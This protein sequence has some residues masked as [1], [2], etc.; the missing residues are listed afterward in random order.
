[1]SLDTYAGLKAA[2]AS[3]LNKTNLTASIPDFITLAEAVMSR[4]ISSIG[5]VDNYA[6]VEVGEEGWGLPFSADEVASV[7]YNG[8]PLTYLSPDRVGEVVNTNPG[9]YTIDGSTLKVAPAGTVT[10]RMTKSFCPLSSSVPYNWLLRSHPDAYLYGSLM[11]AAP[12]LRDDERIPVWGNFFASAIDS[13]NQ[14]EIRR[15][16]GGIIRMQAGPTP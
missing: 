5:Q 11:Q 7:T 1:M 9:Y 6:D 3:T 12:F 8:I 2:I 14:R 4:E 15:Q 16:I 10:I 13:I